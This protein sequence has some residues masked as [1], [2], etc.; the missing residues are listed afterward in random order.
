MAVIQATG[1]EP[2]FPGT[3]LALKNL[4][5]RFKWLRKSPN[6]DKCVLVNSNL[7]N[8]KICDEIGEG[9]IGVERKTGSEVEKE[10]VV[11]VEEGEV[12]I[13]EEHN[14]EIKE[15]SGDWRGSWIKILKHDILHPR[16]T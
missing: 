7:K 11:E 4:P 16:L 6:T 5:H 10:E 8:L 15:L 14:K 2:E 12:N 13:I 1:E 3:L 9:M